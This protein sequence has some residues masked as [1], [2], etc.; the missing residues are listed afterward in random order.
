MFSGIIIPS[1]QL[2]ISNKRRTGDISNKKSSATILSNSSFGKGT[3]NGSL[4]SK[5]S[6]YLVLISSVGDDETM[7]SPVAPNY[8]YGYELSI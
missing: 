3:F 8:L 1:I 7:P 2:A 5:I 6:L 4:I